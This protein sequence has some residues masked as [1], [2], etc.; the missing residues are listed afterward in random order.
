M[1]P[2]NPNPQPPTR[3][4]TRLLNPTLEDRWSRARRNEREPPKQSLAQ[5]TQNPRRNPSTLS[6]HRQPEC[7]PKRLSYCHSNRRH[8]SPSLNSIPNT[9]HPHRPSRQ[10]EGEVRTTVLKKRHFDPPPPSSLF[11]AGAFPS[12]L[13]L[14]SSPPS[15]HCAPREHKQPVDVDLLCHPIRSTQ[16][17]PFSSRRP[18]SLC[19]LW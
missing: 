11:G 16:S 2:Q 5:S 13:S 6:S 3:P 15:R 17:T 8:P 4:I 14:L 10:R 9:Q 18:V 7:Q 12:R 19:C 1:R